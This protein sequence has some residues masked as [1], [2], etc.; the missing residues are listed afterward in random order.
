[1]AILIRRRRRH[2]RKT[3]GKAIH[4]FVYGMIFIGVAA[5]VAGAITYMMGLI[6]TYYIYVVN[7]TLGTGSS[8]PSGASGVDV[9]LV[10]GIIGWGASALL[11][12]TGVHKLGIRI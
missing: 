1:M 11:V 10:V 4:S 6:P 8:L 7:G 3:A 9:K 12:V 5:V 2:R